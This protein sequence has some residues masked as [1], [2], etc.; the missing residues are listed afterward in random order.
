MDTINEDSKIFRAWSDFNKISIKKVPD[1]VTFQKLI[2]LSPKIRAWYQDWSFSNSAFSQMPDSFKRHGVTP[3]QWEEIAS[4]LPEINK[5]RKESSARIELKA[6]E[7]STMVENEEKALAERLSKL[8]DSYI[9]ILKV[10]ITCLPLEDQL[11]ILSVSEDERKDLEK[12]RLESLRDS[13][14]KDLSSGEF[15]DPFTFGDFKDLLS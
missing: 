1:S 11:E 3:S 5:A 8:E 15:R 13:L 10:N 14:L 4:K 2:S 9:K 6:K 7:F 12:A